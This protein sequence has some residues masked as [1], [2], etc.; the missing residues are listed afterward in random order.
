MFKASAAPTARKGNTG[1]AERRLAPGVALGYDDHVF[2]ETAQV[3]FRRPYMRECVVL[4]SVC[5]LSQ[6]VA[7]PQ[8]V[9][10]GLPAPVC[11]DSEVSADAGVPEMEQL[12]R[13][14]AVSLAL[15]ASPSNNVEV[16]LG[17]ALG[18]DGPDPDGTAVVVGWDC[19]AWF[20]KGDRLRQVFSVAVTNAGTV[21]VRTLTARVRLGKGGAPL[22]VS[23]F[24]ERRDNNGALLERSA[25]SFG[26]V[27]PEWFDPRRFVTARLT[28]R[29][30]SDVSAVS[31]S[32]VF[33][34]DGTVLIVR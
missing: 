6:A 33:R 30:Q 7:A 3:F 19:G 14:A 8:A 10:V 28:S 9:R 24:E 4:L 17:E 11:A 21:C 29:G 13:V 34:M 16:A 32:V 27:P 22:G 2:Q 15:A 5:V 23:F 31:A 26:G 1:G 20:V 12:A 25:V 18:G